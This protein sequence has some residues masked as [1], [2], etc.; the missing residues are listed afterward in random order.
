MTQVKGRGSFPHI[1]TLAHGGRLRDL[2]FEV[3]AGI[4]GM[5]PGRSLVSAPSGC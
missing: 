5:G 2:T 3:G 4:T 1:I